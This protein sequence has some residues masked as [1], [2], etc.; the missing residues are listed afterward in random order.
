AAMTPELRPDELA[1]G[2]GKLEAVDLGAV[3][4]GEGALADRRGDP[5]EAGPDF[6]EEHQPVGAARRGGFRDEPREVKVGGI[7][8]EAEFLGRLAAGAEVRRFAGFDLP[9]GRAPEAAV[10]F[11]GAAQEE[12][13]IR[14]V[15]RVE[16]G[17]D[18]EATGGAHE[19]DVE[20]NR[21]S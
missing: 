20:P 14:R 3:K 4:E 7:E 9:S 18:L 17:G 6:V 10:R 21:A 16:Q 13:P 15:E 19:R 2:G 12:D 8:I 1:V 11:A 5:R